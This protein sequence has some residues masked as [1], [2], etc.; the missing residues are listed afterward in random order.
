[1]VHEELV[2]VNHK[3][4]MIQQKGSKDMNKEINKSRN[5]NIS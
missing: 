2:Q 3:R 1:M 5:K 4:Q